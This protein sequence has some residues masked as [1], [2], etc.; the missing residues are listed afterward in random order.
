M[1]DGL[2]GLDQRILFARRE[3]ARRHPGQPELEVL[4]R[5]VGVSDRAAAAPHAGQRAGYV[6]RRFVWGMVALGFLGVVLLSPGLYFYMTT[7]PQMF[8]DRF[9]LLKVAWAMAVDH[10]ILGVGLNQ[11]MAVFN[12]YDYNNIDPVNATF[13][14]SMLL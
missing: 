6:S 8:D 7:R 10:P 12:E 2:P 14:G 1:L 4:R 11:S 9:W 13:T 5:H 3:G